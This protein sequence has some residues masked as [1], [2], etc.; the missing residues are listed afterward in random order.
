MHLLAKDQHCFLVDLL[1]PPP[2]MLKDIQIQYDRDNRL[3]LRLATAEYHMADPKIKISIL[4]G[5]T[6]LAT[7][8][9]KDIQEKL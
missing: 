3:A 6:P 1:P 4:E 9:C 2:P 7:L 8:L 5:D